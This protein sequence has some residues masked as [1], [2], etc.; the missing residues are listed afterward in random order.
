MLDR[1]F[2][3]AKRRASR[4]KASQGVGIWRRRQFRKFRER[5]RE[6]HAADASPGVLDVLGQV[7]HG[8]YHAHF[9]THRGLR[10]AQSLRE[11]LSPLLG[12]R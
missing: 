8:G 9:V 11:R 6:A 2:S 4:R 3:A 1:G 5:L 7:D 12:V 10:V